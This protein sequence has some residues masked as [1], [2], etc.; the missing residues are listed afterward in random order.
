MD[1]C[2]ITP[3]EMD[4]CEIAPCEKN[5]CKIAPCE[6]DPCKSPPCQMDPCEIEPCENYPCKI[7]YL[8]KGLFSR[9]KFVKMIICQSA[10]SP[11]RSFAKMLPYQ[12]VSLQEIAC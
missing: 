5:P 1:P 8:Q 2:V 4:P 9:K 6:M 3:C 10:H 7:A 11:K 12:N